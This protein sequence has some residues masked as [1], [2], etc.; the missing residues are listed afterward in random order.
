MSTKRIVCTEQSNPSATGHGHILAV[1]IG[2][3]PDAA[4]TREEVATVRRN[5]AFG[6]DTYHTQGKTSGKIAYVEL[7]DCSCGIKTIRSQS[8]AVAD[9]NLDNLRLCSWKA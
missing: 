7:W 9:N 5:I 4:T 6:T 1:G 3:D 8:D 2:N